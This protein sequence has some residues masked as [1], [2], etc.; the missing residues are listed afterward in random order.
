MLSLSFSCRTMAGLSTRLST[1]PYFSRIVVTFALSLPAG[2]TLPTIAG[3]KTT[4]KTHLLIGR[5]R[6][7]RHIA[8]NI[9]CTRGTSAEHGVQAHRKWRRSKFMTWAQ[10]CCAAREVSFRVVKIY[11]DTFLLWLWTIV[12]SADGIW[13][14]TQNTRCQP[15]RLQLNGTVSRKGGFCY[16]LKTRLCP[17][18]TFS[19][20]TKR[21]KFI[22]WHDLIPILLL[23]FSKKLKWKVIWNE[24][25][26]SRIENTLRKTYFSM[27]HILVYIGNMSVVAVPLLR[28]QSASHTRNENA[29][30]NNTKLTKW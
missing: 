28:K 23:E 29:R 17:P 26:P 24:F 21:E 11:Y 19:I 3:G 1:I 13:C 15:L 18:L 10:V 14:V 12:L 20:W 9:N 27:V 2:F 4:P 5:L 6:R 25:I 22:P 16:I 30:T 8:I 7:W